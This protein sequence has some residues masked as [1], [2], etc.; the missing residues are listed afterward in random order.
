ME[1]IYIL[2][3][4]VICLT[5]MPGAG[6]STVA[7]LLKEKNFHV[8]IMGDIIREKAIEK[9]IELNDENMGNLMKNLRNEH[10]NEIVAKLILQK[11][12]KLNDSKN[13]IAIDGI[14][15]YEEFKILKDLDFVKLLAIHASST[16]RFDHIKQRDRSDSPSSYEKFLQRDKR[17]IDVG[18][19]EA[20]ALADE[21]VSNN[22]LTITE[23]RNNVE[24]IIA[25][26]ITEFSNF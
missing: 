18:I 5:G 14:R 7:N 26:W 20:I 22:A 6:K 25:K 4:L 16:T 17:E 10:G 2:K 9:K 23:F 12:K 21:V 8:I 19:S 15:S 3:K 11:I 1:V 13:F 24:K